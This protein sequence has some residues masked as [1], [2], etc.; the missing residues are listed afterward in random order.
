MMKKIEFVPG[1]KVPGTRWTVIEETDKKNGERMY[2]CR[3]ECGTIKNVYAKNLKYKKSLSCGCLVKEK[4]KE[5][6]YKAIK[7][8]N[9]VDLTN[10]IFGKVKVLEKI[11]GIGCETVWKC[12][13]LECGKIFEALQHNLLRGDTKSCGCVAHRKASERI[14]ESFGVVDGTNVSII[15]SKKIFKSNTTGVRGVSYNK[16]L[17]KYVAYIGFKGKLY[18]LG[19]YAKL[20]DA[21]RAR[22]R[23]EEEM[24]GNFLEW[25]H[26]AYPEKKKKRRLIW[27]LKTF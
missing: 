3:C 21:K 2:K 23:A 24:F 25:Y 9:K 20:E 12:E 10:K 8:K 11:S 16:P 19:S 26:E 13:C 14:R 6:H 7:E 27:N 15:S 22:E 5:T 18:N 4:L 17:G 1:E